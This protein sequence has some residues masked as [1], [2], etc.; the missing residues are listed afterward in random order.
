MDGE[1]VGWGSL[2]KFH[3]RE[4]FRRTV[5]DSVYIRHDLHR[6]GLGAALLDDLIARARAL[7]HHTIIA[8][9]DSAQAGSI[10]LHESRGFV[11]AAHLREVGFKFN[12]WLDDLLLQKML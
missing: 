1:V 9:I 8:G 10:R 4:A 7:G 11:H 3:P 5:E 6:R 2:S 12:R